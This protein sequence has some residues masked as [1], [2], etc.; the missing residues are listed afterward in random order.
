MCGIVG[1]VDFKDDISAKASVMKEMVQSLIPRG[2]DAEGT[3]SSAHALLGHRRLIVV[4]PEGGAQPM[5]RSRGDKN[6]TITY[7]GELYNTLE[8][9]S[10]LENRGCRFQSRKS[11]TEVLLN[12]YIEWGEECVTRFNGIF[13]FAIWDEEKQTLFMARDRLGVKPLFYTLKGTRF[14][15]ASEIK[16]LLAHPDVKAVVDA[17][18][19]AEIF[20]LGPSRTPGHGVFKSLFEIR[21]GYTLKYDRQGIHLNQ[22]WNLESFPHQEDLDTTSAHLLELFQD[23]VE[24]QLVADVPVCT[25]LSGGL[26]SSAITAVAAKVYRKKGYPPLK[27]FSVDYLENNQYYKENSFETSADGPWAQRVSEFLGTDHQAIIID[28]LELGDALLPSLLAHDLPGMTDIDASL[29]LFCREIRKQAVVALSGECADEI[30]GGYPWFRETKRSSNDSFPWVRMLAERMG[31]LSPDLVKKMNPEAYS[32]GRY[33]EA[34]AEVSCLEGESPLEARIR[35]IFYLNITRFMPTLLDRKDRMSMAWGLEVRVPFSDHRLVEYIWNIPWSMK[36]HNGMSKGILRRALHGLLSDE[37]LLRQKSPYPKTHHPLYAQAVC[38]ELKRVINNQS[39]PVLALINR[40]AVESI[41]DSGQ[42]F[43]EKPWF[44]QLMGD[45]QFMAYLL[46]VNRW[47]LK[48]Q[49]TIDL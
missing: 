21:P 5:T 40:E 25:L 26:D 32:Q 18:S 17:E 6:Y 49:V 9:R 39:S 44:G 20:V 42:A 36:N 48:Y 33:R 31:Y 47:L 13:A 3:W 38:Y 43:M 11:D 37:V 30:L 8:I 16:A 14:L 1:W 4:D 12:A 19:L 45:V 22:Y 10:I 34:L 29:Y 2:P 46:Q 24:R 7:N 35:E 41:L 23:T 28:N 15:F 27:T